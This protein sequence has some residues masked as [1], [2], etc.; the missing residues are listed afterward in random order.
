[1]LEP[2]IVPGAFEPYENDTEPAV[3][4]YTLMQKLGDNA[5]AFMTDHYETFITE[6]DFAEIAGA[7]LS[8]VRIAMPFWAI[9]TI[10]GEP[11][12]EGVAWKYL[13]KSVKP[14]IAL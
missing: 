3:D 10:E 9:E 4:E 7:G 2:F 12:V 8:W 11:F 6:Q 1:M 5:T 14:S 13:L